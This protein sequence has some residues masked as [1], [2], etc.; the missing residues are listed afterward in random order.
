MSTDKAKRLHFEGLEKRDLLTV[1]VDVS[2]D[3]LV[4][5]GT[6]TNDI[7][8]EMSDDFTFTVTEGATV[9]ATDVEA[10]DDVKI[11]FRRS[12]RVPGEFIELDMGGFDIGGD[13][14]V[15]TGA[16]DDTFD[17]LGGGGRIEG[18]VNL[19][20][21]NN[22]EITDVTIE[23]DLKWNSRRE[24]SA[25]NILMLDA[26][27]I[28]DD[29]TMKT[30]NGLDGA[31]LVDTEVGDDVKMDL[32]NGIGGFTMDVDSVVGDD[33][34]YK[35]GN[36]ADLVT[37]FGT[38]EGRAKVDLRGGDNAGFG[39]AGSI[40]GSLRVKAGNGDDLVGLGADSAVG[41]DV[42]L[43]LGSGDNDFDFLADALI[44]GNRIR[45]KGGAHVD[46]IN[47][48]G[49]AGFAKADFKLRNGDD[50]FT[51]E[52]TAAVDRM[53]IDGGPGTDTFTDN[54]GGPTPFDL[55]LKNLP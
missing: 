52:S 40:G 33:F 19:R 32:R 27:V 55:I 2:G 53:F 43:D 39:L 34:R 25:D 14:K 8:I 51:L 9:L 7:L 3:D 50:E 47:F 5:S 16:G 48:A 6:P 31:I 22:A 30:R 45:Y 26:V 13:V 38:V 17:I 20:E 23:D 29:L 42:L 54:F 35:G 11:N 12:T 28:H 4:I 46:T 24:R 44:G 18:D 36:E 15:R 21:V 49:M 41:G 1:S 37:I 10:R